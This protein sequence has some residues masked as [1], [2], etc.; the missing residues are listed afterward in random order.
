[1]RQIFLYCLVLALLWGCDKND[2]CLA[3]NIAESKSIMLNG[4]AQFVMIRGTDRNNPVLLHLHGGPGV[5][6]TGGLRKYNKDLEQDFT[7]IAH[8]KLYA[9]Q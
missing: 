4:Q 1:M 3:E 6:E 5:S 7:L 9:L 8:Q 2:H